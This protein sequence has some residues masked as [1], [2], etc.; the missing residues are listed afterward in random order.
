MLF[1]D[2]QGSGDGARRKRGISLPAAGN[3]TYGSTLPSVGRSGSTVG[4]SALKATHLLRS[5]W[6][7][8]G[9]RASATPRAH[10]GLAPSPIA[11][12]EAKPAAQDH[13]EEKHNEGSQTARPLPKREAPKEKRLSIQ[14][15]QRDRGPYRVYSSSTNA[16]NAEPT[17]DEAEMKGFLSPL[18]KP[19]LRTPVPPLTMSDAEASGGLIVRNARGSHE[20]TA[21]ATTSLVAPT[22]RSSNWSID[23]NG[24]DPGMS[25]MM[26]SNFRKYSSASTAFSTRKPEAFATPRAP[27][28]TA[29][30]PSDSSP[31]SQEKEDTPPEP[32]RPSSGLLRIAARA[33]EG[34]IRFLISRNIVGNIED[35]SV[36]SGVFLLSFCHWPRISIIPV[37]ML[38]V[39]FSL[40]L[41]FLL[42]SLLYCCCSKWSH[43]HQGQHCIRGKIHQGIPLLAHRLAPHLPA[44]LDLSPVQPR[45]PP[46]KT[47]MEASPLVVGLAGSC[48]RC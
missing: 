48:P 39:F 7:H 35:V 27:P 41:L 44:P 23:S 4:A 29:A 22:R 18:T 26:I 47:V 33:A 13:Y 2:W 38:P 45:L 42:P 11:V 19:S 30:A 12:A 28:Q 46:A 37:A 9:I 17:S 5:R 43:P 25:G 20:P 31:L 6:G 34:G 15:P 16:Y 21:P 1:R 24:F 32:A 3:A 14:A 8:G 40:L 10:K 36:V